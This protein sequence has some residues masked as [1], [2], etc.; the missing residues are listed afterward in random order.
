VAIP[1]ARF[2]DWVFGQLVQSSD[3]QG[4]QSSVRSLRAA[5]AA[6]VSGANAWLPAINP[7]SVTGDGTDRIVTV[8]AAG[9]VVFLPST[10]TDDTYSDVG[11][12]HSNFISY[13]AYATGSQSV[14]VLAN[15]SGQPRI[16]IIAI[17]FQAQDVNPHSVNVR[18]GSGVAPQTVYDLEDTFVI[19][20]VEGT[21]GA[22]PVAPS[23]PTGFITLCQIAVA[24]GATEIDNTDITMEI[25]TIEYLISQY[26]T[27]S[28]FVNSVNGQ[29]GAVVITSPGGTLDITETGA[30]TIHIDVDPTW[31]SGNFVESLN[32]ETG[33]VT[34]TS[35]DGSVNIT[36]PTGH[37]VD[38]SVANQADSI[39]AG[40]WGVTAGLTGSGN[41]TATPVHG[42]TAGGSPY[43][44]IPPSN[45]GWMVTCT[46]TA[47][48]NSKSQLNPAVD[49]ANS[50]L[51]GSLAGEIDADANNNSGGTGDG[52][53]LSSFVSVL[54]PAGS[55][56][57]GG[58]V[59]FLFGWSNT[60]GGEL[61]A[62]WYRIEARAI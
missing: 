21:P 55:A 40:A 53:T 2:K 8:G 13:L 20:Y 37:H 45:R 35:G 50:T 26:I 10:S 16:D 25:P 24:A 14:T 46:W 44:T 1:F 48:L 57:S 7:L 23:P 30:H 27:L 42:S 4:L 31:A 43:V 49:I 17:A 58:T 15:G 47:H 61:F 41:A 54:V 12:G 28:A 6:S 5:L 18:S 36:E 22:S 3:M 52:I 9:Q 56:T 59:A 60:S 19:Q 51:G 34:L 33:A 38:L 29:T 39:G 32:G 11:T 62:G